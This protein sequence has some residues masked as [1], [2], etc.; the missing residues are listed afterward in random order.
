VSLH[1]GEKNLTD[2]LLR[3]SLSYRRQSCC[4][5]GYISSFTGELAGGDRA[6]LNKAA[7]PKQSIGPFALPEFEMTPLPDARRRCRAQ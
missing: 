4:L 5:T 7:R 2:G 6:L 1:Y 3:L